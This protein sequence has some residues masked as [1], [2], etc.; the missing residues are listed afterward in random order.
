MPLAGDTDR[1]DDWAAYSGL[2][3][4]RPRFDVDRN[5]GRGHES[6]PRPP[7]SGA[8]WRSGTLELGLVSAPA[9]RRA[10]T[11]RL[12]RRRRAAGAVVALWFL[13]LPGAASANPG[14]QES[15]Y[16]VDLVQQAISL[17]ANQGGSERA[18]EKMEDAL[19]APD[20]AGVDLALVQEAAATLEEAGSGAGQEQ[21]LT[22]ARRL[23]VQAA[24]ALS[25]PPPAQRATG[26]QTGTTLVLDDFQPARG[27]SDGGDA[28]LLAVAAV[29]IALGLWLARRLR[30]HHRISELRHMTGPAGEPAATIA[31]GR[32]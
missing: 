1:T 7:G 20:P 16:S 23:L 2:K 28:V 30:P 22:E 9:A 3:R 26:V 13:L 14:E 8:A 19:A 24:P 25:E 12:G 6:G 31:E 21:A 5:R 17:I 4:S 10:P 18:L 11:V 15:R 32:S 27:I 29:A